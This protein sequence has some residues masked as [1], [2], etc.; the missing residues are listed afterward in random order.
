MEYESFLPLAEFGDHED[1]VEKVIFFSSGKKLLTLSEGHLALWNP[2]E[3]V[4]LEE[5]RFDG[6]ITHLSLWEERNQIICSFE[7]QGVQL[8]DLETKR[9]VY[10]FPKSLGEM[11]CLS[12]AK[13]EQLLAW[14]MDYELIIWNLKSLQQERKIVF[15]SR[16]ILSFAWSSKENGYAVGDEDGVLTFYDLDSSK[17]VWEIHLQ[18]H[19]I[20]A[21]DFHDSDEFLTFAAGEEIHLRYRGSGGSM[22]ELIGFEGSVHECCFDPLGNFVVA[23]SF[24]GSGDETIRIFQVN[25]YHLIRTLECED[26]SACA[27]SPKGDLL[28]AGTKEGTLF[29]FGIAK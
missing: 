26:L 3:R 20:R 11:R 2:L 24:S 8:L 4:K 16:E 23:A 13:K 10:C 9:A 17:K 14:V 25:T 29:S 21:I 15:P 19:P 6:K 1:A 27:L 12:F 18:G 22:G 7:D 5:F 28:I